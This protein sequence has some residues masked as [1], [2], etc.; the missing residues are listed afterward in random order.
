ME[1][2]VDAS[3]AEFIDFAVDGVVYSHVVKGAAGKDVFFPPGPMYL[4]LN[5]AIDGPWPR[6]V[7]KSTRFPVYHRIDQVVV[8]QRSQSS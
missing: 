5:T 4:I 7:D 1:W 8:S 2:N 6:P 3:G